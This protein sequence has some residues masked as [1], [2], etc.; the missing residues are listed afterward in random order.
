ML[1]MVMMMPWRRAIM[2]GSSRRVSSIGAMRSVAT[3][4][5]ID[6]TVCVA[7]SLA[8]ITPADRATNVSAQKAKQGQEAKRTI[9]DQEVKRGAEGGG[10]FLGESSNVIAVAQ[11]RPD[12]QDAQG[13]AAALRARRLRALQRRSVAV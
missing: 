12:S 8:S 7:K 3:M 9:I 6:S 10:G 13:E 1:E 2:P 5:S 4:R 11:V